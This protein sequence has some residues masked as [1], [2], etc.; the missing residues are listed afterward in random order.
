MA[1]DTAAPAP[2]VRRNYW[3]L[4]TFALGA[5]AAVAAWTAFPPPPAN[6]A[7]RAASDLTALRAALDKRP[8][9]L[10]TVEALTPQVAAAL[11]HTTDADPFAHYLAGTGF[12]VLAEQV[13]ADRDRWSKAAHHLT[14]VDPTRFTDQV[15][16]QRYAFRRAKAEAALGLGDPKTLAAV[17]SITPA[18]EDPEGERRRLL[19]DACRRC[20]PPDLK[21]AAD[22]LGTYLQGQTKLP[23][24]VVGRYWLILA[25]T[26][27][28]LNEPVKARE[29]LKEIGPSA[30]A[31]VQ[32]VAKAQLARL[33]AADNNWAEAVTLYEAALANPKLPAELAGSLRYQAGGGYVRLQNPRAAVPFFEQAAADTGPAAAA[34]NVRLAEIVLRDPGSRGKRGTAVDRLDAAVRGAKEFQN[35]FVTANEV[36][37]AFEEAIQVCLNESDFP[38]AARAAASY[39]AVAMPGRDREKRAEVNAAWASALKATP[40]GAP[41]AAAKFRAAADDFSVLAAAY[42]TPAGKADLMR[43]AAA[44]YKQA[45]DHVAAANVID[46]LT[47]TPDLPGDVVAAAWVE[48]ADS[49]LAG[50][51]FPEAVEALKKALAVP[52]PAAATARVKLAMAYL[53]RGR[54]LSRTAATPQAQGEATGM[55]EFGRRELTLAANAAADTPA[56]RTAHEQALFELGKLLLNQGVYADAEARFRQQVQSHPTGPH[57]DQGRLFLGSCLL[58]MARG[59]HQGGRPPSDADAKLAEATKL[60]DVLS[61]SKDEYL[62]T[63]ADLRL[64]NAVL[65]QKRYD[66]LPALCDRLAIRY[67]GKVQEL[68]LLSMRYHAETFADRKAD[69]ARTLG[70]ME[71]VY[72]KLTDADFPGGMEEYTRAYWQKQWFEP[73]KGRAKP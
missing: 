45:G 13:P 7:D 55:L 59:D 21:R 29:R 64:A 22:E 53:D 52:G 2:P 51:Q 70:R 12:V 28:A 38:T 6:P 27:I 46:L 56:E 10:P 34:A 25:E 30:P 18:G 68:V 61:G 44:C 48:K 31:E 67:A 23:P 49:L 72:A 57:A 37:A 62:R 26:H 63:Q 19:A 20:E 39:P 5:A 1:T 43:R 50:N 17:L 3:Q 54:T 36:R 69:A 42:P 32:A 35:P 14:R 40:D 11:E 4:P 73:L 41:L 16:L 9:D 33:A 71:A 58:V 60:F 65:L 15:D 47:R 8:I 66:E 24:D